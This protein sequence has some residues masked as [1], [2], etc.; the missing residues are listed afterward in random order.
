MWAPGDL[1]AFTFQKK[2]GLKEFLVDHCGRA[3]LLSF[4]FP[5]SNSLTFDLHSVCATMHSR[6]KCVYINKKRLTV[7]LCSP[8][9]KFNISL[10]QKLKGQKSCQS[11]NGVLISI[12]CTHCLTCGSAAVIAVHEFWLMFYQLNF[13]LPACVSRRLN[14]SNSPYDW[15]FFEISK[16]YGL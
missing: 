6:N 3:G 12:I 1:S 5:V 10:G 13:C 9:S 15:H 2:L 11:F 14:C 7:Y 16:V 8:T 4:L